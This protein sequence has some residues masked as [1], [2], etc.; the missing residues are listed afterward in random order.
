MKALRFFLNELMIILVC[1][2]IMSTV[3]YFL[4]DKTVL[5]VVMIIG[6]FAGSAVFARTMSWSVRQWIKYAFLP[7]ISLVMSS[8]ASLLLVGGCKYF[9]NPTLCT[10]RKINATIVAYFFF[11]LLIILVGLFMQ[12]FSRRSKNSLK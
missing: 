8:I 3:G 11:P 1:G 12:V 2:L 6:Y 5:L 4:S 9:P 7:V 10:I